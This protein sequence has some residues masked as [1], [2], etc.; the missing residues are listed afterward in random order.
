M[1]AQAGYVGNRAT[2][3]IV[4]MEGNQALPGVGDPST[5]APTQQRR[6]LY[7][8]QPLITQIS[9]TFSNAHAAY[10]SLQA[11][12][13]RRNVNGLEFMAS[14]T[15]SEAKSSNRGFYGGGSVVSS[16]GAYWQ[17]AYDSEAE[18]GPTFFDVR[19]NLVFSAS[20]ELPIGKDRA[21]GADWNTLMD[22]LLGG[23]RLSGIF[24]TRTGVP[25]TITDGRNRSLQSDRGF[26]RPNCVGDWK[27][28][29]QSID[30]WLDI[31]GF[32]AVPLGTFGNCPV[33]YARAPGYWNVDLMLGKRFTFATDR[34]AEFRIEAFNALNHP[35]MGPP[36]RDIANVNT[37][38]TIRSTIGSPRVIELALKV[39]F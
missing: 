18:Y 12:L 5:W 22:S 38:G 20:Y 34:Y 32:E 21:I 1:S 11:S 6:P 3:L 33:G 9:S 16:E 13:R 39:Y 37:F 4:P 19:H 25:V 30:K 7:Q 23:W 31:T 27:P 24:Q 26:E 35:N 10:N 36:A 14:Y 15:L 2:H 29:D 17:N 8:A 28:A